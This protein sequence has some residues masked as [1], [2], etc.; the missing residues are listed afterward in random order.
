MSN[1]LETETMI[2]LKFV[3]NKP[4]PVGDQLVVLDVPKVSKL[5]MFDSTIIAKYASKSQIKPNKYKK[6]TT[7]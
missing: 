6:N 4:A 5:H 3:R 7:G 2:V 1:S